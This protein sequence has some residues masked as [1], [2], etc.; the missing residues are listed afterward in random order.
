MKFYSLPILIIL[1]LLS[2]INIQGNSKKFSKNNILIKNSNLLLNTSV[3]N[4]IYEHFKT[5]NEII[6]NG[7]LVADFSVTEFPVENQIYKRDK[8][9]STSAVKVSGNCM[10]SSGFSS[11]VLEVYRN[12]VL[13]LTETQNLIYSGN[14]AN[15]NFTASINAELADYKFKLVSNT[16]T[17]LKEASKVASGDIYI[18]TGQS[19]SVIS[20]YYPS[21]FPLSNPFVRTVSNTN[22]FTPNLTLNGSFGIGGI[23]YHFAY[24]IVTNEEIPVLVLN[25]GRSGK[26]ISFFQRNDT[27]K[28]STHTN[29][30]V[31]L[32]RYTNAGL[33]PS[34]VTSIIWY[35]GESDGSNTNVTN[36]HNLFD[37]LYNDWKEDYN[38]ANFYVFQVHKGCGIS[39]AS[40][41]PE[42]HRQIANNYT[43]VG[44][45]S[46]NGALQGADN[47]HYIDTDGYEVLGKRLYKMLAFEVY[48]SISS[49]GVYSPDITNVKYSETQNIISFDLLPATDTFRFES[50]AHTDFFLENNTSV[51]ITGGSVSSNTVTLNLSGSLDET[52]T[53]LSY[54]G[55]AKARSPYIKNQNDIGMLSFKNVPIELKCTIPTFTQIAPIC[56]G[57]S[58]SALPTTSLNN[59]SGAW[60][61][62]LNNSQSTTYTFTPIPI[63]GVCVFATTMTIE[64]NTSGTLPTFTQIAPI[65]EGDLI[66]LPTTS[67]NN[68]TGTWSPE[69]DYTQTKTYTFTPNQANCGSTATMIV[70][71]NSS[72]EVCEKLDFFIASSGLVTIKPGSF[73]Y[74]KAN[75]TIADGGLL[76]I[77]SDAS[78]SASLLVVPNATVTGN[79]TYNRF[80]DAD[81][82]I[83]GSPISTQSIEDFATNPANSIAQNTTVSPIK[84]AIASYNVNNVAGSRWEYY[85]VDN[86]STASNFISSKGYSTLRTVQ[87][88]YKFT[89]EFVD[90]DVS[91]SLVANTNLNHNWTFIAN[92]YPYFLKLTDVSSNSSLLKTNL[93]NINPEH[94]ALYLWDGTD[95]VAVNYLD[96]LTYLAPGQG[97]VVN[98][99]VAETNFLFPERLQTH[100]RLNDNFQKTENTVP[101]IILQ[102]TNGNARK[103]TKLK[104]LSN[105]T[106]GLD[107]GY[108]AGSLGIENTPFLLNTHLAE[109]SQGVNFTLQC[110][111]DTN[112]ELNKIP[113]SIIA[114]AN[115]TIVFSAFNSNLPTRINVFI[116]DIILNTYT[117]INDIENYEVTLTDDLKGIGRFYLYTSSLDVLSDENITLNNEI[118]IYKTNNRNVRVVGAEE[119]LVEVK[120]FSILGKEVLKTNFIANRI[121][122]IMLPEYIKTGIYILELQ[123]E[124]QKINKK[125]I[126]E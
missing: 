22:V 109:N 74:L 60:S 5:E 41:I 55:R 72:G 121:N 119:G 112:Y 102:L 78:K 64:V 87:G 46:T 28:E 88:N 16:G 117:K 90:T 39:S 104:F 34:D 94:A 19:N 69:I 27:N 79:I 106:R 61:P 43:D 42:A 86:I 14:S 68:I 65:C 85:N 116:E 126:V 98:R 57:E 84:Y 118:N 47:C 58:L 95:Y 56:E 35:Q 29:Y 100:Q 21:I 66:S 2:S 50:G 26:P 18:V 124:R 122:D 76:N 17:V 62:V 10:S 20:S 3:P 11:L 83:I 37:D 23:G 96:G 49:S 70:T 13:F 51:T 115:E 123:S 9:T 67:L 48:N 32:K 31:L 80:V 15:F 91:V 54:L 6:N 81:W 12:N 105:T 38:P 82:N 33:L 99:P 8:A 120:L 113:L 93:S 53:L 107:L 45:I 110:L 71:V 24:E 101:E 114:K 89:G 125:L 103:Q 44:I 36:Y 52:T 25:G 111:P 30:G 59:I 1:T 63:T 4:K 77:N 97:F 73:L 92:P 40:P 75:T 108:D 7:K